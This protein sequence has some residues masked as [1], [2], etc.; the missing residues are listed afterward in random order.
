MP[1][2]LRGRVV[3]GLMVAVQAVGV[4]GIGVGLLLL[5]LTQDGGR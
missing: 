3:T 1:D 4:L 5:V 2:G